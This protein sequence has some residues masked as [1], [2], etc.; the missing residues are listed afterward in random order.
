MKVKLRGGKDK[1]L[2]STSIGQC[3]LRLSQF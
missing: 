3:K 1:R 2:S